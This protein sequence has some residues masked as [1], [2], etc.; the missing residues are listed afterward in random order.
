MI[1]IIVKVI[2][3]KMSCSNYIT[4]II[5]LLAILLVAITPLSMLHFSINKLALGE[6]IITL[7][8]PQVFYPGYLWD[9]KRGLGNIRIS[10]LSTIWWYSLIS[11]IKP[12]ELR[13]LVVMEF[14]FM[15][16]YIGFLYLVKV[17]LNTCKLP[18]TCEPPFVKEIAQ[19]TSALGYIFSPYATYAWYM[20]HSNSLMLWSFLPLSTGLLMKGIIYTLSSLSKKS[21]LYLTLAALTATTF[22]TTGSPLI[23][24]IF[25]HIVL[26]IGFILLFCLR[27][28]LFEWRRLSRLLLSFVI[29]WALLAILNAYWIIFALYLYLLSPYA[30]MISLKVTLHWFRLFQK[31][32]LIIELFRLLGYTNFY[33]G[34]IPAARWYLY[35]PVS[36]ILFSVLMVSYLSFI[37]ANKGNTEK[38]HKVVVNLIYILLAFSYVILIFFIKGPNPPI[39]YVNYIVFKY[40]PL[41]SLLRATWRNLMPMLNICLFS[42]FAYAMII[43]FSITR[44]F[45]EKKK[46]KIKVEHTLLITFMAFIILVGLPLYSGNIYKVH[47]I[48]K[49]TYYNEKDYIITNYLIRI[50]EYLKV[51]AS[52]IAKS[53]SDFYIITYPHGLTNCFFKWG[54][55]GNDAFLTL[56]FSKTIISGDIAYNPVTEDIIRTLDYLLFRTSSVND[57]KVILKILA[58]F[59]NIKYVVIFHDWIPEAPEYYPRDLNSSEMLHRLMM[60]GFRVS[61]SYNNITVLENPFW[62]RPSR[63]FIVKGLSIEKIKSEKIVGIPPCEGMDVRTLG[64][65]FNITKDDVF[66]YVMYKRISPTKYVVQLHNLTR[67][68]LLILV[69][70]YHPNWIAVLENNSL[71]ITLKHVKLVECINAWYIPP[72]KEAKITILFK[73][74]EYVALCI[75]FSVILYISTTLILMLIVDYLT[76][77]S[78][79]D[80]R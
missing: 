21:I 19:I 25:F 62:M 73:P 35:I 16:A 76:H 12:L 58:R 55:M 33:N 34:R 42:M 80:K 18:M 63:I 4:Y 27:K 11:Y 70:R 20:G 46:I 38:G 54:Y 61:M 14:L 52:E 78:I 69:Q 6:E 75:E 51:C 37:F 72:T 2:Y 65:I 47:A 13:Q 22:C 26:I 66:E 48:P 50:P 71:S 56:L 8:C 77:K 17:M 64:S 43:L 45:R 29:H 59:M 79:K 30:P 41:Y 7:Y 36:L 1:S 5:H 31:C 44:R 28:G 57:T 40:F 24:W 15:M 9:D 3:K 10:S 53:K 60:L 67:P 74:Q 32:T 39:E 23:S 68:A 49:H